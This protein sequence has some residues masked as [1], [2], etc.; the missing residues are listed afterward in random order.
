[1]TPNKTKFRGTD[2]YEIEAAQFTQ[3][4][5]PA[6]PTTTFWGSPTALRK[7]T[8]IS[9]A[10]SWPRAARR[11][12][13][14]SIQPWWI[15]PSWLKSPYPVLGPLPPGRSRFRLRNGS[16]AGLHR[17]RHQGRVP[18]GSGGIHKDGSNKLSI[19]QTAT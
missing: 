10:S 2:Y 7:T 14:K 18:A 1:L 19:P 3:Q 13:S 16:Q 8:D 9:A 17:D 5:H 15:L 12:S 6:I 11:S 4:L